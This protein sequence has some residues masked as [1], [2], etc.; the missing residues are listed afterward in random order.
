MAAKK[1]KFYV[2]W[3]GRETGIFTDWSIAQPLVSG[4]P[5]A[6]FKSFDSHEV[7]VA[8][9]SAGPA[10]QPKRSNTT[11]TQPLNPGRVIN[12]DVDVTIYCDGG[13]D[14]NPGPSGSGLVVY[15][16]TTLVEMH[17]GLYQSA[18]TNNTAE[19]NALH[20][21]MLIAHSRLKAGCTVQ[22]LCDSMYS[23]NAMTTW[24]LGWKAR[25]WQKKVGELANRELIMQMHDDYLAL[26]GK[27]GIDHIKAHAGVEGNELADRLSLIAI[28][29]QCADFLPYDGLHQVAALLAR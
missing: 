11:R 27:V 6:K 12:P 5:G 13:C 3:E 29:N 18:G 16:K 15:Q 14:P 23:I 7:A 2:V 19:L 24:A 25:G 4:H 17:Y 9:F 20:Q 26:D 21:A 1:P 22:I 28:E 8:A 10:Q